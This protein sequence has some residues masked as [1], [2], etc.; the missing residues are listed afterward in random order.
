M[1]YFHGQGGHCNRHFKKP[2][3]NATAVQPDTTREDEATARLDAAFAEAPSMRGIP[4]PYGWF[5]IAMAFFNAAS[6]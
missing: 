5:L 3:W 4:T 6:S 2:S 1:S